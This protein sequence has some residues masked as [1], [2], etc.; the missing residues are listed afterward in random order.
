VRCGDDYE[1]SLAYSPT[2]PLLADRIAPFIVQ[3]AKKRIELPEE[4]E[5]EDVEEVKRVKKSTKISVMKD[6]EDE[7]DEPSQKNAIQNTQRSAGLPVTTAGVFTSLGYV[8]LGT[9]I[10]C[11]LAGAVVGTVFYFDWRRQKGN[12]IKHATFLMDLPEKDDTV[13]FEEVR[14]GLQSKVTDERLEGIL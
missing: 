1:G 5:D 6:Q 13:D 4:D 11:V 14:K 10:L 9:L 3:F 7:E 12:R 8:A 2:A